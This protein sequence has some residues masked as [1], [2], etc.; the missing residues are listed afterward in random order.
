MI[1][2]F[3]FLI[4]I[5]LDNV[6]LFIVHVRNKNTICFLL[7]VAQFMLQYRRKHLFDLLFYII[8]YIAKQGNVKV[9]NS[10]SDYIDMQ[11][12]I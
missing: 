3:T 6:K 2:V 8:G 5:I 4:Q 9:C 1:V 7:P 10:T 11:H 12:Q